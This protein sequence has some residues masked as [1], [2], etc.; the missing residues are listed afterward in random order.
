[1][2]APTPDGSLPER[3]G[4][5]RQLRRS[6]ERVGPLP[7]AVWDDVRRPWRLR[8]LRR[9]EHLTREGETERTFALVVEG[10][11]RLYFTA[12]DGAE[13]TVA[14]VYAPDYTGVP[15]SF[16][17]QTPSAYSLQ[18]LSDGVILATDHDALMALLDRHRELERWAWSLFARGLEGRM[19][20]EREHLT[21][22]ARERYERLL[23]ESPHVVQIAPLRH[24]ASY[25]GMAPETLSRA[26]AGS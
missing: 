13:H 5:L 4:V 25:L 3:D 23:R 26:R 8:T 24:V 22:T 7:E 14:F 19:K 15:D 16:F 6:F 10:V 17:F 12:P 9:G 1:M 2:S 18:A 20:R 21:M 11:Q